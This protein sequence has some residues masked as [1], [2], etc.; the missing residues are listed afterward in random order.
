MPQQKDDLEA[1]RAVVAALDEFDTD[2]QERILRWAREKLSLP[3][4]STPQSPNPTLTPQPIATPATAPSP[5]PSAGP[6]D[7]RTFYAEKQPKSDI[8]FVAT[9]AYFYRFEAPQGQRKDGITKDDLINAS[10]LVNRR[11]PPSAGQTLRNALN[12]GLLDR[13]A[14]GVYGINSVGE[15]FVAVTL[16]GSKKGTEISKPKRAERSQRTRARK[17]EGKQVKRA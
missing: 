4:A 1:V 16:P 2:D 10:R 13:L 7:L 12:A 8:Q 17:P 5:T 11:R 9:V 15:N 14:E 6:R 3:A